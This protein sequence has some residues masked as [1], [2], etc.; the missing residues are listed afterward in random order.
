MDDEVAELLDTVLSAE[1]SL[2]MK[3]SYPPARADAAGR[4]SG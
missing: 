2:W 3:V 1:H 4:S